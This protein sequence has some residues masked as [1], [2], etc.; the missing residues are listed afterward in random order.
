MSFAGR[1]FTT[2]AIAGLGCCAGL[3]LIGP[4]SA[5]VVPPQTAPA[6]APRP[7]NDSSAKSRVIRVE[8]RLSVGEELD[9]GAAGRSVGDQFVFGGDLTSTEGGEERVVGSIDGFCVITGLERNAGQCASTAVLPEGQITVQGRQAGI[10]APGPVVN[11]VTGGT[12]A[13]RRTHGQVTQRVLTPATW[14]LTFELLD[15]SPHRPEDRRGPD[16]ASRPVRPSLP[17]K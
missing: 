13:F 1:H 12:G 7:D 5:D 4:A 14:Q 3:T 10:P 16:E 9:L 15:V 11:A 6:A 2:L 17:G 8:A